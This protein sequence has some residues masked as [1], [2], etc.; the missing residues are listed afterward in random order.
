MTNFQKRN[1][2]YNNKKETNNNLKEC[3]KL[4]EQINI[5]DKEK[6]K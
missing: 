3:L 4:V 1:K 6:R 2:N 5:N